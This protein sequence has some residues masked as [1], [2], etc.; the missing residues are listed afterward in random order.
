MVNWRC[1]CGLRVRRG[2]CGREFP[3]GRVVPGELRP[4]GD[5]RFGEEAVEALDQPVAGCVEVVDPV[6]AGDS[7]GLEYAH[8]CVGEGAVEKAEEELSQLTGLAPRPDGHR[9]IAEGGD[10]ENLLA[11]ERSLFET[12]AS[13]RGRVGA[14]GEAADEDAIE[15]AFEDRGHS[16]PPQ[17]ELNDNRVGA[18]KLLLFAGGLVRLGAVDVRAAGV[19]ADAE[20]VGGV[21]GLG[22]GRLGAGFTGVRLIGP[23]GMTAV[24]PTQ[25]R[26]PAHGVEIGCQDG[27]PDILQVGDSRA[28][29]VSVE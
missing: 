19:G 29:Q 3:I 15:P 25:D 24:A 17:G 4:V 21:D 1:G 12:E 27:V 11:C 2:R 7:E 23:G 28:A 16:V 13:S 5:G 14:E 9:T 22:I 6:G 26:I 20:A 18:P 10:D 8:A